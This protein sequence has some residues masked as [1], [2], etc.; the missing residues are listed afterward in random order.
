[1]PCAAAEARETLRA[2]LPLAAAALDG[3]SVA[4]A[5]E[6]WQPGPG[7]WFSHCPSL[8]GLEE[9]GKQLGTAGAM[10]CSMS[11]HVTRAGTRTRLAEPNWPGA[12]GVTAPSAAPATSK[13]P[14]PVLPLGLQARGQAPWCLRHHFQSSLQQWQKL[15]EPSTTPRSAN[16]IIPLL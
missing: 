9:A 16:I 2:F 12:D 4:L 13:T 7:R 5:W 14:P 15:L 6:T 1:M 10:V 3:H 11:L 8:P